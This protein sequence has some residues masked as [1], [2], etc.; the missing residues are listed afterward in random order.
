M[1]TPHIRLRSRVCTAVE[2]Q[3]AIIQAASLL[4]DA[5]QVINAGVVRYVVHLER[6]H[7][8]DVGGSVPVLKHERERR[9]VTLR[10]AEIN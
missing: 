7:A 10:Y 6:D 9:I 1:S 4:E 3:F 2:I 8:L 5:P